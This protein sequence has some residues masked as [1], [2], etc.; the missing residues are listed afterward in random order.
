MDIIYGRTNSIILLIIYF[1]LFISIIVYIFKKKIA[2]YLDD[3]WTECRCYPY[4][5]PIAGFS[6]KVE[7]NTFGTRTSNNFNYC[8]N[9]IFGTFI[10]QLTQPLMALIKGI[11]GG[12]NNIVSIID[13]FR[14]MAS[15][16]RNMFIT[17]VENTVERM[18]NSYGAV[19]YLQEKMKNLIKKQTAIFEVL[20]HFLGALPLLFYSYSYGPIPRFAAWLSAYLGLLVALI[21][22]CIVCVFGGP[23]MKLAACPICVLCFDEDTPIDLENDKKELI[24]NLKV[25]DKIKGGTI[26]SNIKITTNYW[27]LFNYKGILVSGGHLVFDNQKWKRVSDCKESKP[28]TKSCK[29]CCLITSSNNIYINNILFRD[30]QE[31]SCKETL[32]QINNYV[33]NKCNSKSI[34]IRSYDELNHIYQWG[35][36][37]D[38]LIKCNNKFV[39]IKEIVDNKITDSNII[40]H[41]HTLKTNEIFYNYNNIIVTGSTLFKNKDEWIRI[42]KLKESK[43]HSNND[44]YIYNLITLDN[45][46]I[47]SI[48]NTEYIFKDFVENY[49]TD[50]NNQIDN[51]IE[52]HLNS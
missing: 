1:T 49:D 27:D 13:K 50:L 16:L 23:F 28:I 35:F 24:K 20:K 37:K 17:L 3:N 9:N 47:V 5:I 40:G 21:I 48:N 46:I 8:M 43:I 19:I 39:K 45:N 52:E 12:M 25:N 22:A 29:L 42:N 11:M 32:N 4:V 44:T 2:S 10:K 34:Y 15:I 6:K 51:L 41:I 7:G 31:T 14:N 33:I 30:Y 18:Q 26:I 38:T 36:S